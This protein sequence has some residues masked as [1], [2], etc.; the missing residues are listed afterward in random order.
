MTVVPTATPVTTPV[1][2][3]V[4]T[5]VLLLLHTPPATASVSVLDEPGQTVV[6]P[7]MA[8]AVGAPATV[9]VAVAVALPQL[10]VTV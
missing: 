2:L 3:I 10:V 9:T 8:P 6:E 7:L 4:A 5:V 1:A